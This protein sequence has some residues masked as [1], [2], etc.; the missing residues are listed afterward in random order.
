MH[1]PFPAQDGGRL[2]EI[3]A[4]I[5]LLANPIHAARDT[6]RKIDTRRVTNPADPGGVARQMAH[7][8]GPKL[9]FDLRGDVN[10]KRIGNLRRDFMN[11]RAFAATDI[12]R[13]SIELISLGGQQIGPRDVFDK[14]E[15]TSLFAVLV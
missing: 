5:S 12:Y 10:V 13:Q 4:D 2:A 9:A 1:D 7:L 8:A 15:I 6:G 3:I 11:A 14:G